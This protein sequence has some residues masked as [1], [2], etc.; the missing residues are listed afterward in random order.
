MELLSA[1]VTYCLPIHTIFAHYQL[2]TI[3][4]LTLVFLVGCYVVL[5]KSASQK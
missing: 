1:R 3:K 5:L 4:L 2:P